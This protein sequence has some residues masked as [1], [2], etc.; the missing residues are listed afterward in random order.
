MPMRLLQQ[1]VLVVMVG[2]L[3]VVPATA[4]GE[5][6][7][8]GQRAAMGYDQAWE[9]GAGKP[10][11]IYIGSKGAFHIGIGGDPARGRGIFKTGTCTRTRYWSNSF[12]WLGT[13]DRHFWHYQMDGYHF[14][15]AF[16]KKP[17]YCGRWHRVYV[18][19][20]KISRY[21]FLFMYATRG[22]PRGNGG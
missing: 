8:Y 2:V 22:K 20:P 9:A 15:V 3:A 13:A 4:F 11:F 6:Q 19:N 21:W 1:L 14:Q 17:S 10:S 18:R 5:D 7:T 16:E 12:R